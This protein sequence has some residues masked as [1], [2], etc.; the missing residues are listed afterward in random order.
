MEDSQLISKV[1]RRLDILIALELEKSRGFITTSIAD[2]IFHLSNLG[3][4]PAEIADILGKPI[5][6]ITA[7]LSR[8]NKK[9][10]GDLEND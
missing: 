6:Y 10:R 2:R 7:T 3:I 8:R 9:T 1:I 5:N 4:T